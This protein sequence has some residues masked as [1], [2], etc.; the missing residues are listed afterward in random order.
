MVDIVCAAC[1][2]RVAGITDDPEGPVFTMWVPTSSPAS[3]PGEPRWSVVQGTVPEPDEDVVVHCFNDGHLRLEGADLVPL[4]ER[5][6]QR[7]RTSRCV[8]QVPG[9]SAQR[10]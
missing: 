9:A 3:L 6:R 1:G 10:R 2:E 5:Y 4:V 8:L 7:G